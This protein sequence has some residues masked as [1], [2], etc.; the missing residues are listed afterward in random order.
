VNALRYLPFARRGLFKSGAPLHL[1]LFVTGVCNLRCRHCFHWKEVAAGVAG[2]SLDEVERL[3]ASAARM[4]PLLWVSFGGG[5]PFMREDLPELSRAFGRRGLR[6]LAIPTNGLVKRQHDA[7]ERLAT[8]NPE[9]FVSVAVSFDGTPD[10]H[11]AIRQVPGGH[12]RSMGAVRSFLAQKR[13][14]RNLGVGILLTVT[15][16]NQDT[17]AAHMDELVREL[18]P[19]NVTINLARGTALDESLLDVDQKYYLE[20]VAAKRRLQDEGVLRSFD[21]PLKRLAVARDR[22]MYEHVARVARG[23]RSRHLPCTAGRLS[24]VI[25]EDGSVHPCEILGRPLGN[26]RDVDWDLRR[27][28]E[29]SQADSLRTEIKETRCACTWECAQADNVLFNRR[30]WPGLVGRTLAGARR[31]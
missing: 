15:K 5:E 29:S 2:P 11:D 12:A 28:W 31:A 30:A 10:V 1:T 8:E 17:L 22:M 3:A 14:R 4:G 7:V 6:H 26:L 16:E 18:R 25:F 23:D 24:A 21:F 13:G 20:V 9:T 19:D 27:V